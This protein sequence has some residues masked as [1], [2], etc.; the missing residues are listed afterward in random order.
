[1]R[2]ATALILTVPLVCCSW[3]GADER[4]GEPEPGSVAVESS[5]ELDPSG[6]NELIEAAVRRGESWPRSPALVVFTVVGDDEERRFYHLSREGN[7]GEAPDRMAAVLVRD[8]FLDDSVRGD[9]QEITLG[10]EQDGT[11]RILEIRK[12]YR[13]WR[14]DK[15]TFHTGPC[16]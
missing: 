8:G 13:C 5:R 4:D 6:M 15:D 3:Y 2:F 1:M 9:R 12:A 11:W 7:R 14:D 10:R 16:P